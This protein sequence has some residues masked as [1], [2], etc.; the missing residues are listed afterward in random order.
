MT[1]LLDSATL[2]EEPE[3]GVGM[4]WRLRDCGLL[5]GPQERLV[6]RDCG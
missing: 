3:V 4:I 2:G 5:V 1:S 6:F